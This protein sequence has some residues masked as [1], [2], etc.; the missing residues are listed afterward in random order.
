MKATVYNLQGE[1]KSEV[2]LPSLFDA[3]IRE[4]IVIKY[5]E[6][7]KYKQP[8]SPAATAG[9]RHSASG[10]I[11]H[12]RHD[13]KGHY[14]KGISRIPRKSMW[15]RGNQFYWIGAEITST[16]GGR[17]VHTPKALV[18]YRKINKKEVT[19]A[20]NSGFA[21]TANADFVVRRYGTLD[22]IDFKAPIVIAFEKAKT[23]QVFALFKKVLGN[24]FEVALK[25]KSVRPGR[26]KTRGRKYKSNAGLLLVT[27][28][29]EM[30]KVPGVDVRS[31]RNVSIGDLYP[32]GRLTVYTEK[33]L[34]EMSGGK[35]Q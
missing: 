3:K 9:R 26:G 1:K 28:K 31:T 12:Q 4:D 13:W 25:S 15:R 21:A 17:A 23:K 7:D 19:M 32:L 6:A 27:A 33:A 14:G 11:S 24:A 34:H 30:I 10:T 22:K 18:P 29:D 16:R 2:N 35:K 20:M 5:F 8:Y